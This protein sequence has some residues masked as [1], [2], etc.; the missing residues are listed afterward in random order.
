[1]SRWRSAREARAF[2]AMVAA[3]AESAAEHAQPGTPLARWRKWA[4]WHVDQLE[5][6]ATRK[7]VDRQHDISKS[8][9]LLGRFGWSA[10]PT[11]DALLAVV[12]DPY[13][14][15]EKNECG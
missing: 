4:Q 2:I 15:T 13:D 9:A 6:R 8:S 14:Q 10:K 11:T 3:D 1:M 5:T 7:L 12:F